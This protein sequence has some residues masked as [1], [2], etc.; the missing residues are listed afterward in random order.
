MSWLTVRYLHRKCLPTRAQGCRALVGRKR[1][2]QFVRNLCHRQNRKGVLP[3]A[4]RDPWSP[5]RASYR[6]LLLLY[7]LNAVQN[8]DK[9]RPCKRR[10]GNIDDMQLTYR[11]D[12]E[13][14]G[15]RERPVRLLWRPRLRNVK[16]Q[17]VHLYEKFFDPGRFGQ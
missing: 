16:T 15:L 1:R 12:H 6:I 17:R 3:R 13:Q 7:E 5:E 4:S 11:V 9:V 14:P 8:R 2:Q 10:I